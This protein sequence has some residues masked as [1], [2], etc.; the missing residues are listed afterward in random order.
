MSLPDEVI[1]LAGLGYK[2]HPLLPRNKI[3]IVKNWPQ[4][5][6]S[7]LRV[8]EAWHQSHPDCNWGLVTGASSGV[9][10]VDV[11][12][13]NGGDETFAALMKKH[14]EFK[15][16]SAVTG[17][18][19]HHYFFEAPPN[20][21][22]PN[23]SGKVGKGID[24]R[25]EAGQVVIPPSTHPNGTQYAWEVAP[26][27]LKPIRAPAWLADL[28]YAEEGGEDAG[29]FP[30]IGSHV[31]VGTRNNAVFH[32]S[33]MLAR[34]GTP[35]ELTLSVMRQW[36]EQLGYSDV[37]DTELIGTVESAYKKA[38]DE[39]SK[40]S[41]LV[42]GG[43]R[44]DDDNARR[45]ID[46]HKKRAIYVSGLGWHVWD[47]R[48]WEP[49]SE[50]AKA[51]SLA[52]DTIR[53]LREDALEM[54]RDPATQKEGMA[55]FQWT[56]VSLN[57]GKLRAMVELAS[58]YPEVRREAD[59]LD[60]GE[61]KWLLNCK[62]GTL[63][64]LTGQIRPHNQKDNLTKLVKTDYDPNAKCPHWEQTLQLAF[65]GD[66]SLIEFM[67]RAIGYS[68]S[69][70]VAEQ[71][72]FICWGESGNNG[73]STIL[74]AVHRLLGTGYAQMSDMKVVTSGD[75]D[76]RVAS[77]LA[78]LHGARL[79]SMNEAEEHQRLSESLV[80]QM[81]GGD[82]IEACKKYHEPFN[83]NPI[84][85]LWIRTNEKPVIRGSNDAIWRRIKLI[86]FVKPIPAEKRRSRDEVD[87]E[88]DKEAAGILAWAVRGFQ[89]WKKDG[90]QA[91]EEVTTAVTEYRAEMDIV[92]Q[93]FEACAELGETNWCYK[94]DLY[95]AFQGW[96]KDNGYRLYMS[97]DSFGKR[98]SRKLPRQDREKMNGK[99]VWRGIKINDAS[100]MNLQY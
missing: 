54:M 10:V 18:G 11:D 85:K 50:D 28:L 29:S 6:T 83:Y 63:D 41:R 78:K 52:V 3:P 20:K 91:P 21:A 55:V 32:Q 69:G 73:K 62:N 12:P 30:A 96:L 16:T 100:M 9:F 86:P 47:G 53:K 82:T 38:M 81:T 80:K 43:G 8:I 57:I 36:M 26:W 17:S 14:G 88:L 84:F 77:S 87:E 19:G 40:R 35:R 75:M 15:T 98:V 95:L 60:G 31:E 4:R 5:A 33:Y 90:L 92:A 49:D 94:N 45:F 1:K 34:Q 7:D 22:V 66:Q 74:E 2:L 97:S 89:A 37:A 23:S 79:V 44:T 67:Q 72:L 48:R 24:I 25:G 99:Y 58:T 65:D 13:K 64:L 27:D 59:Q 93:F 68:L 70:S 71:C 42:A 51:I 46:D 39:T 56:T 76:N 61:S